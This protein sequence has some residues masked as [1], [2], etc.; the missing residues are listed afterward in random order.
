MLE[1]LC[2]GSSVIE[3]AGYSPSSPLPLGWTFFEVLLSVWPL[4]WPC[5]YT[6]GSCCICLCRSDKLCS[7]TVLISV[8]FS[9]SFI[10]LSLSA[11]QL[12]N[13]TM[14]L[15]T[16]SARGLEGFLLLFFHQTPRLCC[17]S[18]LPPLGESP[19][20]AFVDSRGWSSAWVKRQTL[21]ISQDLN[22]FDT[23]CIIS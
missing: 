10:I 5:F 11:L 20:S 13:S 15:L 19:Y 18:L 2:L 12:C 17:G 3:N 6:S 8:C 14:R 23:L 4:I 7:K 1:T 21:D 16:V 9:C 22:T